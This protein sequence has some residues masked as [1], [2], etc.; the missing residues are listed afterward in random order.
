MNKNTIIARKLRQNQTPQ[1]TKIWN[2][3]RNNQFYNLKF[4]RQYPIGNYIVDFVC[5]EEK[6]IIE[7]DGGQHNDDNNIKLDNERTKFLEE[8]GFRVIRFWN[9]DI[10]DNLE[11]V[12][13]KLKTIIVDNG[14]ENPSP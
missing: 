8:K 3:L 1:E 9:N 4:R 7:I 14:G 11:G 6:I 10:D 5:K 2:I 13:L 12:F